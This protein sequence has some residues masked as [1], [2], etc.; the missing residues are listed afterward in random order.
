MYIKYK[1]NMNIKQ[2]NK[3][4]SYLTQAVLD[5]YVILI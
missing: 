1:T 3:D 4:S 2:D 5:F